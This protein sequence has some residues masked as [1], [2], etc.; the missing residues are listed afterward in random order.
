MTRKEIRDQVRMLLG[1]PITGGLWSDTQYNLWI[2]EAQ[3]HVAIDTK[4]LKS[5]AEFTTTTG[6]SMYDIGEQSLD[7]MLEISELQYFITTIL[8]RTLP[9]VSRD[10]LSYMQN[11]NIGVQT[12]PTCYCYEDRVIEF[13]RM[14]PGSMNVRVYYYFLP[15]PMTDDDDVSVIPTKFHHVMIPFICWKFCEADMLNPRTGYFK[16]L[17]DEHIIQMKGLLSPPA[18]TYQGIKDDTEIQYFAR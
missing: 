2:N 9:C 10:E 11:Q 1:E 12:W 14:T 17:Y 16:Q 15:S 18:S 3:E 13:D 6:V 7:D 4:C 8:Y 5:Y